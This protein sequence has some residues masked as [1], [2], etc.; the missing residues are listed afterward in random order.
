MSDIKAVLF[1]LD[2]TL[3]PMNTME[4]AGH[5]MAGLAKAAEHIVPFELMQK[6]IYAATLHMIKTNETG[7]TNRDLFNAELE[8][9]TGHPWDDYEAPIMEFIATKLDALAF[10]TRP[11]KRAD[12]CVKAAKAKGL[13]T[14]LATSPLFPA[15]VTARRIAWAGLDTADF[16]YISTYEHTYYTKPNAQYY[17]DIL[18]ET[19]LSPQE[20]AMVGNDYNEDIAPTAALGMRTYWLDDYGAGEGEKYTARGSFQGLMEFIEG[21]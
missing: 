9:L 21:L 12:A 19:G 3:L 4:F 14:I 2:G 7:K 11:D 16:E 10:V 6:Y 5:Y 8:R 1:D 18:S 20:C 15:Q 13:R 17:L